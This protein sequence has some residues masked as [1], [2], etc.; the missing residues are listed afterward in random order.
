MPRK[1]NFRDPKKVV[2]LVCQGA[3][4]EPVYFNNF[5]KKEC[6]IAIHIH[7]EAGKDP[8]KIINTAKYLKNDQYEGALIERIFCI[9][10][11]DNTLERTLRKCEKIANENGLKTCVSNPCFEIWFLLHFFYSTKNY[12]SYDEVKEAL[13]RYIPEYAKNRDI[14]SQLQPNQQKAIANAKL[15]EEHHRNVRED[16]SICGCNPSTQVVH[17]IEYLNKYITQ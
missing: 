1:S 4:T 14:F 2:I 9:Y 7:R 6:E 13:I 17:I 3:E 12:N 10:D 16:P 15:L 11:V 5:R 8:I